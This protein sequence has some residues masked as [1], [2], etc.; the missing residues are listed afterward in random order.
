[1]EIIK[2][3]SIACDLAERPSVYFTTNRERVALL[4]RELA[5][6]HQAGFAGSW[7][8]PGALRRRTGMTGTGAIETHGNAQFDPYRAT[9]GLMRAAGRAGAIIHEHSAVRRIVPAKTGVRIHS[10]QGSID[11]AKVVIATGYATAQFRPLAGRFVMRHTYVL[12]TRPMSAAQRREVGL[13]PVMLWDTE[14]PY[15]YARWTQGN[16]LLIGGADRL[17]QP[18]SRRPAAFANA[19]RELREYFEGL[20][21]ALADIG[22]ESAWEGLFAMTPDS[23]PY[24]GPHRRYPNHLFALGY[25]GNGMTFASLAARM[26]REQWLG[27]R[28]PDHQLFA[29]NRQAR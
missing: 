15:H 2:R 7:L 12:A 28:S 25:G 23:L 14:R 5:L 21:P 9:I 26:V 8:S 4:Q 1:V 3:L 22:I 27:V 18:G 10:A 11:A 17:V 20:Y 13:G 24:I 29:F 16:R 6:R 19:M